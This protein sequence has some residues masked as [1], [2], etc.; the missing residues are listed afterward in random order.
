MQFIATIVILSAVLSLIGLLLAW[1]QRRVHRF[2][3]PV[4]RFAL[5]LLAPF[6]FLRSLTSAGWCYVL[7][8]LASAA[9]ALRIDSTALPFLITMLLIS[10]LTIATLIT[11]ISMRRIVV[12]RRVPRHLWAG[13]TSLIELDVANE[14]RLLPAGGILLRDV[15]GDAPGRPRG[16][17]FALLLRPGE[18]QRLAYPIKVRRRGVFHFRAVRLTSTFPL[19][20]VANRGT[21]RIATELIVYPRLGDIAQ[22]FLDDVEAHLSQRLQ[23]LP[24]R[25]EDTFRSL[26][27][28]R[29]GDNPRW[30]HW[31]SS[32]HRGEL[33]VREWE[34]PANQCLVIMLDTW[35]PEGTTRRLAHLEKAIC[36]AASLARQVSEL[37]REVVVAGFFPEPTVI[38]VNRGGYELERVY[39][40]L[41]R[42][43]P[44]RE[45]PVAD[46]AAVVGERRLRNNLVVMVTPGAASQDA[47]LPALPGASGLRVV[48]AS[49]PEFNRL[50]TR[51]RDEQ[52][53]E[54]QQRLA[55]FSGAP[56]SQPAGE[57]A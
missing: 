12:E 22:R 5:I 23:A 46:V 36:F 29:H 48:D 43:R 25:E 13:Q 51:R 2:D 31:R 45:H 34:R 20:L 44:T 24:V 17:V 50:F 32:A 53:Q 42:L 26:R 41:A 52:A 54:A 55:R 15:L 35:M 7:F 11:A 57:P 39:Q 18:T 8:T 30:I 49:T 28:F 4:A 33:M 9:L 1:Q 56:Q 6:I 14:S 3:S 27:D 21:C 38:N 16:E 10:G 37:G 40:A 19:G 47:T